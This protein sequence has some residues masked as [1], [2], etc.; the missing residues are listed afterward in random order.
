MAEIPKNPFGIGDFVKFAPS[1]RAAGWSW[2]S[3]DRL[4]MHPGDTG[5]VTRIKD[6]E[7][8]FIDDERGGFHWECF[9]KVID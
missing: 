7:Y 2:S 1:E 8:L 5:V 3:F 9:Q 4:R 6:N